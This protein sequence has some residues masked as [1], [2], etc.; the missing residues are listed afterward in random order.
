MEAIKEG[1]T[2]V[3][4]QQVPLLLLRREQA[5]QALSIC[6]RTLWDLTRSREIPH[7]NLGRSVRYRLR[8]LERWVEL[9]P[10]S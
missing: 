6:E 4:F 1:E 9:L 8:D 5:A 7:V 10:A 2:V 3:V